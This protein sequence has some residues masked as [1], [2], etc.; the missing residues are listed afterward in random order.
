MFRRK[1]FKDAQY[2]SVCELGLTYTQRSD[3]QLAT[4]GFGSIFSWHDRNGK[5][6]SALHFSMASCTQWQQTG[7]IILQQAHYSSIN[8]ALVHCTT[9][10][11]SDSYIHVGFRLAGPT[12]VHIYCRTG[13]LMRQIHCPAVGK[14]CRFICSNACNAQELECIFSP[15]WI[16][17]DIFTHTPPLLV[18]C[19]QTNRKIQL[20]F[21]LF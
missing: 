5:N 13:S 16:F 12:E 21:L 9:V 20:L 6:R 17:H 4:K 19:S 2:Q 15:L 7:H 14:H 8:R 18:Y 10:R 11:M 1:H 3:T